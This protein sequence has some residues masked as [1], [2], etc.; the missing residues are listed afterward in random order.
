MFYLLVP[1][2]IETENLFSEDYSFL[3]QR[4]HGKVPSV[5]YTLVLLVSNSLK[6]ENTVLQMLNEVQK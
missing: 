5:V 1:D 6:N 3:F 2:I 4:Q